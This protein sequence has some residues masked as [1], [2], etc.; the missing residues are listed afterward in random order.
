MISIDSD[1]VQSWL[2]AKEELATLKARELD[3]R[4]QICEHI[5]DGKIKGT[6]NKVIGVYSLSAAAKLNNKVEKEELQAMWSDL[7]PEE[8]E[9]VK[10]KPEVVAK[11]Y[12]K[13]AADSNLHRVITSK[14]G[15]PTLTLKGM[16]K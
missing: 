5:L 8:K 11:N 3:L 6:S 12:G 1:K 14:P 15:T 13:I 16:V 9:C 4:N 7:S 2:I 10:F